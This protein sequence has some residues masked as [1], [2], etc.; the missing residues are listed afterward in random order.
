VR[1]IGA[2]EI[3]KEGKTA[4]RLGDEELLEKLRG[5]PEIR[6]DWR[7]YYWRCWTKRGS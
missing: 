4:R 5:H 7:G 3:K 2:V 1:S 6:E